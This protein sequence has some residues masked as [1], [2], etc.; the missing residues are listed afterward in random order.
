MQ[1]SRTLFAAFCTLLTFSAQNVAGLAMPAQGQNP[2]NSVQNPGQ[3]P[4]HTEVSGPKQTPVVESPVSSSECPQKVIN[5]LKPLSDGSG[6]DTT[7]T[8]FPPKLATPLKDC[9]NNTLCK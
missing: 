5:Y 4:V 8:S 2:Q 3:N 9:I 1:L 6:F 7:Y